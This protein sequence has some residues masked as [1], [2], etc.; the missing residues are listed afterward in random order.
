M[1]DLGIAGPDKGQG[2]KFLFLPPDFT[3]TAPEGWYTFKSPTF[4][5][6]F[7]TRGF[8]VN[9]NPKP[10]MDA[11]DVVGLLRHPNG[12]FT[13]NNPSASIP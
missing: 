1:T 4:A 12:G 10:G 3:G 9:G 8:Q 6:I 11:I 13:H 2:G 5:N 7:A